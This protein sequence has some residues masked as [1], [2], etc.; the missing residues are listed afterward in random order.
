M[1]EAYRKFLENRPDVEQLAS[2]F[3][4]RVIE[5]YEPFL[6]NELQSKVFV[7]RC[8][9]LDGAMRAIGLLG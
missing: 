5:K 4:D 8:L 3:S 7:N 6:S 2:S 9:D 1:R